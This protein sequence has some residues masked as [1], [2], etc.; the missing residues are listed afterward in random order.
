[1]FIRDYGI[2]CVSGAWGIHDIDAAQFFND[3]DNTAPITTEGRA[4][5]YE[6]IRDVPYSGQSSR[7][8]R[9]ASR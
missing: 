5:Y 3:S 6:D 7:S 2:G 9:T 1:M 8:T 4:R